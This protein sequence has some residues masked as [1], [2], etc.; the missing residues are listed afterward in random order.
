MKRIILSAAVLL[1]STGMFAQKK[2]DDVAKFTAETIDQGKIK[3]NN[4]EEVKFV[5]T[6]ISKEPLIIEQANPTCGCTIGDYTKTPIAPGATGYVSAKFN[7]ATPGHFTK[8]LTVKFAGA[9]DVKNIVITGD[10]VTAEEY[11]KLK[12]ISPAPAP[13]MVKAQPAAKAT[14]VAVKA[15]PAKTVKT[16]KSVAAATKG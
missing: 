15:K 5:V 1:L 11:D 2:A 6:N 12:G 4:P 3:Q 7:A 16:K 9:D 10:V 8:T 13:A 14:P